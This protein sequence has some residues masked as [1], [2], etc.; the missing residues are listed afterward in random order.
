MTDNGVS[1]YDMPN[2][3]WPPSADVSGIPDASLAALLEGATSAADAPVSLRQVADVLAALR[4]EP[5]SDEVAG[6]VAAIA[7]FRRHA[8]ASAR[9][10]RSRRTRPA[11]LRPLPLLRTRVGSV[12]TAVVLG[13]GGFA[14]AAYA[15]ALPAAAQQAAHDAIGAPKPKASRAQGHR[16]APVGPNAKGHA[17]F[18]LCSA[19]LQG[20]EN[21]SH[22]A[23][24]VALRNLAK[25][26]G[27][28]ANVRGY[29]ASVTHPGAAQS[30]ARGQGGAPDSGERTHPTGKPP[31]P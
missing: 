30:G 25:A 7:E 31:H 8:G 17:A 12:A 15:G 24:S 13:L 9:S 28:A 20:K 14:A 27:G 16:G 19:Y 6:Q 23:N 29:C 4:A 10:A 11:A 21:G 2:R 3:T 18:G 26:A 1:D 22:A 5:A